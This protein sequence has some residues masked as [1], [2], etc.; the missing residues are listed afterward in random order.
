MNLIWKRTYVFGDNET[1]LFLEVCVFTV[2]EWM[3]GDAFVLCFFMLS[4][5]SVTLLLLRTAVHLSCNHSQGAYSDQ[6]FKYS[7][8]T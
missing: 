1:G 3:F 6:M 4:V 7:I 8:N 5:L 2:V